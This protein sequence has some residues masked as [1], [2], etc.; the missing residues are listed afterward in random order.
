MVATE[1]TRR[2]QLKKPTI[3]Q[4]AEKAGVHP[5]TVSRALRKNTPVSDATRKKIESIAK[6]FG[7]KPNPSGAALRAGR[8]LEV[9]VTFEALTRVDFASILAELNTKLS[10]QGYYMRML[11]PC[12]YPL[13]IT[14]IK[15]LDSIQL[16][17]LILANMASEAVVQ[18]LDEHAIPSVWLMERPLSSTPPIHFFGSEDTTAARKIL[19][20][21]HTLG[22]RKIAHLYGSPET[23]G[24]RQRKAAYLDFMKQSGLSPILEPAGY[25]LECGA[26]ASAALRKKHPEVTAVFC[27][28]DNTAAGAMF[29]FQQAGL[30][31]PKDLS[32]AGFGGR[33]S[34]RFDF[35]Y[36]GLTT[37]VHPYHELGMLAVDTLVALMKGDP[38]N[39]KDILLP[40]QVVIRG[41]TG[42]V[43]WQL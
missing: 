23:F 40:A 15:G 1:Q 35:F 41:S 42:F 18:W 26:E 8:T 31:I 10:R 39:P 27:S 9:G 6:Q 19:L 22:H 13:T 32:I 36:P 28:N 3:Y 37:A 34:R 4:I 20:H 12:P 5:M 29:Y 30:R 14:K 7:Y 43:P 24:S 2:L 11:E 25:E 21:L 33:E 16:Q 17:G 38:L